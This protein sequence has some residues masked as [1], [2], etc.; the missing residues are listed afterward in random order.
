MDYGLLKCAPSGAKCCPMSGGNQLWVGNRKMG[1]STYDYKKSKKKN[2]VFRVS[3][4]CLLKSLPSWTVDQCTDRVL[5]GVGNQYTVMA[6][7]RSRVSMDYIWIFFGEKFWCVVGNGVKIQNCL[8]NAYC[9]Y[10]SLAVRNKDLF[11]IENK[12]TGVLQ[13]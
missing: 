4:E 13:S 11:C 1:P 6:M 9:P 10:F 12:I 8:Y 5:L 7:E 3:A 2:A